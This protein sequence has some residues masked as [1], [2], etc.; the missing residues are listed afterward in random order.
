[1]IKWKIW[2]RW[3]SCNKNSPNHFILAATFVRGLRFAFGFVTFAFECG[4]ADGS[5]HSFSSSLHSLMQSAWSAKQAMMHHMLMRE[6]HTRCCIDRTSK[7]VL[8]IV[9]EISHDTLSSVIIKLILIK[10]LSSSWWARYVQDKS[11]VSRA[12]C[13]VHPCEAY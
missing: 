8:S 6:Q 3:M 10:T 1:M 13:L 12:A 7:H 9:F 4:A 11:C 2:Y 5:K